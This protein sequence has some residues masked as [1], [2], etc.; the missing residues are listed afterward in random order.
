VHKVAV[1]VTAWLNKA[2]NKEMNTVS[3]WLGG[4]R[5]LGLGYIQS[6]FLKQNKMNIG[7]N[8]KRLYN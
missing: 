6:N 8:M 7:Y 1:N 3:I 5:T 4:F 2:T